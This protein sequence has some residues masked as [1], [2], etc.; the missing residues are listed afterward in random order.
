ME[1]ALK[2]QEKAMNAEELSAREAL[3]LD[4][5]SLYGDKFEAVMLDLLAGNH[6][7]QASTLDPDLHHGPTDNGEDDEN[8]TSDY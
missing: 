6:P 7:S 1:E 8:P 3:I 5:N 4:P 2:E